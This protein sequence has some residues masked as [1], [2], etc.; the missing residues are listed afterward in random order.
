MS[1]PAFETVEA[2]FTSFRFEVVLELDNPP[3]G[4]TNPVCNAAFAECSGLEM[5]MEPKTV[6]EGGN[7]REQIHLMGPV[8]YGQLTLRRG[9][10]ANVQLW[11]WFAAANQT[12]R[13]A[14]AQGQVIMLDGT[15]A[16]RL[17]FLLKNCLPV[18]MRGPSFNARD[19][20]VAIEEMSLV[21]SSLSVRLPGGAGS[22]LGVSGSA[23]VSVS[24]GLGLSGAG[25]ANFSIG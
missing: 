5:T 19:G 21:Y 3:P 10:T 8:S 9:I 25:S 4:I 22:G 18:K 6:R 20:L 11:A 16:Q 2:P 12:G 24:G 1:N 23:G 17:I 13:A 14:T 15:G 7:N